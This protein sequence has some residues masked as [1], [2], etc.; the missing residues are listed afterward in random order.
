MGDIVCDA[1]E[2]SN[3][4][5]TSSPSLW[6]LANKADKA[7]APTRRSTKARRCIVKGEYC[8]VDGLSQA[9][10]GKPVSKLM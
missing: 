5:W 7:I 4:G 10:A 2:E 3:K 1:V 6:Y 8:V 9:D